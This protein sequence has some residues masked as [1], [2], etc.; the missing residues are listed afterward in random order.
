MYGEN[1]GQL[2]AELATLLRQHRIQQR[3]GGKGIHTVPET[4]TV[5][6]RGELGHQIARFRRTVLV[7][8][9]QAVNASSPTADLEGTSLRTH[10]TVEE[11]RYRLATAVEAS[12]SGITSLDELTTSQGFPIVET[13]RL[14]AKAAALGEHDFG[15]GVGYVQL[16]D[17]QCLTVLKD[18]A[19]VVNALVALDRRYKGIPGWERL[20]EQGRLGQAAEVCAASSGYG[21]A[22][23]TVDLRGWRPPAKLT[24]DPVLPG[25]DGI[26]QGEYNLLVTL[27]HFPNAHSMRVVLE[28]QLIVSREMVS[29]AGDVDPDLVKKWQQ[30]AETYTLLIHE[31]RDVR[32]LL[33]N[34][35][36][37]AGQ[38]AMVAAHS[39]SLALGPAI[40]STPLRQLDQLFTRIDA[41]LAEVIERG[42]SQR[43]YLLRVK[44]PRLSDRS[45]GLIQPART[46]YTPLDSRVQNP[47]IPIVRSRLRPQP[48]P[49]RAPEGAGQIRSAFEA[50]ITHRPIPRGLTPDVPSL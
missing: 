28:S 45:E 6:E 33:G 42:T 32:G 48:E 10:Q 27:E 39:Q 30:R 16:N 13:W 20:K 34:G 9:L 7:W 8:C 41:R 26:L 38:A 2:R 4:T 15:A 49:P 5:A 37:A 19:E 11:L 43:L 31:T 25:L 36:A 29:R 40:D 14:A 22:N 23:Y 50:A 46:R 47:L 1:T 17:D 18:A 3:L 44:L 24:C 21:E 12:S 35:G